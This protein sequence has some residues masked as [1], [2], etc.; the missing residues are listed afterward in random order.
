MANDDFLFCGQTPRKTRKH[1]EDPG[2][3]KGPARQLIQQTK[4]LQPEAFV[5]PNT[6]QNATPDEE[7]DTFGVL[8]Q[9]IGPST[10]ATTDQPPTG[11]TSQLAAE[12]ERFKKLYIEKTNILDRANNHAESLQSSLAK[13]KIPNKP[14]ITV[15]PMVINKEDPT[16]T[17]EWSQ[18]IKQNEVAM[19]NCIVRHL[20]RVADT[21]R[22]EIRSESNKA[23]TNLKRLDP[24]NARAILEEAIKQADETRKA[25]RTEALKRKRER[26][27]SEKDKIAAKK[28]KTDK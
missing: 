26:Q 23:F 1:H 12:T 3:G 19:I 25:S 5:Q 24:D 16:F 8:T 11:E 20:Q 17:S 7:F 6:Q 13:G 15:K 21:T 10:S 28:Q 4:N 22:K 9:Y 27:Q 18:L 2:K 14:Q